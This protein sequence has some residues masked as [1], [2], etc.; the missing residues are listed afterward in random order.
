MC[1][2]CSQFLVSH[3]YL[4]LYIFLFFFFRFH[5]FILMYI[6]LYYIEVHWCECRLFREFRF[7][8]IML[9]DGYSFRNASDCNIFYTYSNSSFLSWNPLH[10]RLLHT[11]YGT[12]HSLHFIHTEQ[13]LEDSVQCW[14]NFTFFHSLHTSILCAFNC[15]ILIASMVWFSYPIRLFHSFSLSFWRYPIKYWNRRMT[16]NENETQNQVNGN[17]RK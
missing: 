16:I 12:R 4:L 1:Y 10:S 14:S 7:S 8:I 13:S 3:I 15:I 17:K 5:S 9:D 2:S 6:I 11:V